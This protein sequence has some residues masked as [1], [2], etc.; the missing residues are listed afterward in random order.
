MELTTISRPIDQLKTNP[1]LNYARQQNFTG[2]KEAEQQ[3]LL[4]TWL[5]SEGTEL[6]VLW[7]PRGAARTIENKRPLL[8]VKAAHTSFVE[9]TLNLW[10]QVD[11]ISALEKGYV[12]DYLKNKKNF[13]AKELK[14]IASQLLQIPAAEQWLETYRSFPELPLK[15]QKQI[16]KEQISINLFYHL[17]D[18][19]EELF[20]LVVEGLTDKKLRLTVQEARQFGTAIRRLAKDELPEIIDLTCSSL[21]SEKQPNK[22]TAKLLE[23]VEKKAYPKLTSYR[24]NFAKKLT[25]L[26]IDGRITVKPPQNFE[27]SYLDFSFRWSKEED[28]EKLIRSVKK[29]R[30]LFDLV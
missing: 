28:F 19:P 9:L 25:E 23:E 1:L 30:A 7:Q 24:Q 18:L 20:S 3:K 15:L 27:G 6:K 21:E 12:L 13:S 4:P 10:Q 17:N 8:L 29:C 14:Q 16:Q 5:V 2:E 26:N 11:R 22:R